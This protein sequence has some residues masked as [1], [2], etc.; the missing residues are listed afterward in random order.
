MD[1]SAS[2]NDGGYFTPEFY[3]DDVDQQCGMS[4]IDA[5]NGGNIVWTVG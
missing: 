3:V 1:L 4:T 2:T 5:P